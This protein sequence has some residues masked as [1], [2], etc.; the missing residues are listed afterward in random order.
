[1]SEFLEAMRRDLTKHLGGRLSAVEKILVERASRL[2][3]YVGLM[4]RQ[5]ARDKTLSERNSRQY[6][7]WSKSLTRTLAQLG[8]KG[9]AAGRPLGLE[10]ITKGR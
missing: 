1:L 9:C 10:D 7:A 2:A 6:L 8:I 4:D 5:A 3:L